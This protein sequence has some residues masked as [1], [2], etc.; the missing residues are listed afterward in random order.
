MGVL[1]MGRTGALQKICEH[2]VE[3][4]TVYPDKIHVDFYWTP[5]KNKKTNPPDNDTG[6]VCGPNDWCR[7][8][9]SNSHEVALGG[10]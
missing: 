2:F 8:G 10:F 5:V 6:Q 7:G 3:R 1:N 4:V 9:D